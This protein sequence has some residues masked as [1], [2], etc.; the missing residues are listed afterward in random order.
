MFKLKNGI[1]PVIAV[2][3]VLAITVVISMSVYSFLEEYSDNTT[4]SLNSKKIN[5]IRIIGVYNN[6]LYLDSEKSEL[7]SLFQVKDLN[8]EIQCEIRDSKQST[9]QGNT[10]LLMN[11]NSETVNSTHV[12]DLSGY[13]NHGTLG[14]GSPNFKEDNCLSNECF[15]FDGVSGF[16]NLSNSS[17][18]QNIFN[19][20]EFSISIW[21]KP[22]TNDS[23]SHNN[24]LFT[25]SKGPSLSG[26]ALIS[27]EKNLTFTY[28]N[29]L[30]SFLSQDISNNIETNYF[31]NIVL[32]KKNND[33][34]FYLN[35]Q[36]IF[37]NTSDLD[38]NQTF[39]TLSDDIATIG[40]LQQS[41]VYAGLI[42][43]FAIYSKAL[44]EDE[45]FQLYNLKQSKFYEQIIS[46]QSKEIDVTHCNLNKDSKYEFVGILETGNK[47]SQKF[48]AN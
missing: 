20:S 46:I 39:N 12:K 1:S 30:N 29:L 7:F 8:G 14:G 2:I 18:F 23:V 25:F 26:F 10:R 33:L 32:L 15:E 24:R 41:S 13:N 45:I 19:E 11:F 6:N 38:F 40:S 3:L 34:K 4:S 16:I 42:D 44:N 27:N 36:K 37:V 43:E 35:G 9:F 28:R 21:F 17:K 48:I 31:S 5:S 47:I 22:Y